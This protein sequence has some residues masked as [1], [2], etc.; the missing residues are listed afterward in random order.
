[1][2]GGTKRIRL[3]VCRDDLFTVVIIDII[4][5]LEMFSGIVPVILDEWSAAI[6]LENYAWLQGQ[7]IHPALFQ[8]VRHHAG[9]EANLPN[10]LRRK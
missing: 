6:R 10:R 9:I 4:H 1:M 8:D 2:L 7:L 5:S 3:I